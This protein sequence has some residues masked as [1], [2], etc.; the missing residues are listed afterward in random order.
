M[1]VIEAPLSHPSSLDRPTGPLAKDLLGAE[2]TK[3]RSVRSTF[4]TLFAAA[5]FTIGIG[6]IICAVYAAQYSHVGA[7]ERLRFDA[8]SFSLTGGILAQIAIAVLGVMVIT[9]EFGSGMVRTSFIATP[10]RIAVLAAKCAVFAAVTFTVMLATCLAAFGIGQAILSS[11]H[12]GVSIGSPHAL[13]SIVGTAL[14]LT[15]LGLLSL[16]IGSML[17]KTAGAVTSVVGIL[18]VL[19]GLASL[20]PGSLDAVQRFLPSNAAQE[21]LTGGVAP[22]SGPALLS[23]WI[24]LGVFALYAVVALAGAA[25]LLVRRDP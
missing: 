15:L 2:W 23:P 11:K 19:P 7:D 5:A 22:R 1:A 3:I 6:A 4:W 10:R 9:G 20:L 13:R 21:I 12:I 8:G 25:Y 18:F 24:G 14:Y 17:R 16:G